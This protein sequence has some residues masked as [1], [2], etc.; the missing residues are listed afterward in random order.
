MKK[1]LKGR[2]IGIWDYLLHLGPWASFWLINFIAATIV[3][4]AMA[5]LVWWHNR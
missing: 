5:I 2:F 1:L 3:A 4:I